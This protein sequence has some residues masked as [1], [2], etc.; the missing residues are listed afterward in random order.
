MIFILGAY[1]RHATLLSISEMI[2][3]KLLD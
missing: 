2:V 3:I 1:G